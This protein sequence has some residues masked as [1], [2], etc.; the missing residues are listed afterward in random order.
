MG[1][2]GKAPQKLTTLFVKM[3]YFVTVNRTLYQDENL[4]AVT[5]NFNNMS[6]QPIIYSHSFI[7]YK[8]S[9]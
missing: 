3:C 1:V 9:I 4:T 2:R 6:R 7:A 8:C 5:L